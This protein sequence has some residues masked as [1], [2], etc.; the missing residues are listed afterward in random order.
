MRKLTLYV[1]LIA[2]VIV[3][4]LTVYLQVRAVT[5]GYE[6]AA[7]LERERHLRARVES[8]AL[9]L[10]RQVGPGQTYRLLDKLVASR[11]EKPLVQP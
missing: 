2:F 8:R 3:A 11:L 1:A 5:R 9:S 6:I 10:E 4:G 7:Q